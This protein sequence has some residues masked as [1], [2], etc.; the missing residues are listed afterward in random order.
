MRSDLQESLY[1]EF[2]ALH[3][4][5]TLSMSESSMYWGLNIGEGWYKLYHALC[6]E[7]DLIIKVNKLDPDE[8]CF[9]QVKEKFGLLRV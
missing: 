9:A 3:Q 6:T 7:L 8:Y 2:P 5:H 1:A 4:Q